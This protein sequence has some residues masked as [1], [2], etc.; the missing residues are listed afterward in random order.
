MYLRQS[1][2]TYTACRPFTENKEQIKKID[3]HEIQNIFIKKY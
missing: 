1:G 2:F 3:K